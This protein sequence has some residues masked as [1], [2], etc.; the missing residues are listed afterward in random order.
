V[1]S[2]DVEC[3]RSGSA[4]C[5]R[6]KHVSCTYTRTVTT[7]LVLG[8]VLL[9]FCVALCSVAWLVSEASSVRSCVCVCVCVFTFVFLFV[10]L[11]VSL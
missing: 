2:A 11:S 1:S 5:G 10:C 3:Y 7:F 8:F 9:V 6:V 4:V